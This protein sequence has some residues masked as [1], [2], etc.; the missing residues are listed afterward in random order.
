MTTCSCKKFELQ[1]QLLLHKRGTSKVCSSRN[2]VLVKWLKCSRT[3]KRLCLPNV[4][5][6]FFSPPVLI[7]CVHVS[8]FGYCTF[9]FCGSIVE[10]KKSEVIMFSENQPPH[11]PRQEQSPITE[12]ALTSADGQ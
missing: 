2:H 5:A 11:L 7:V 4:H 1:L 9:H 8:M 3:A 6:A 12:S 10:E